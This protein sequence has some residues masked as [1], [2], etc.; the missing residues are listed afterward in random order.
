ME[1]II[2]IALLLWW[3]HGVA[4]ASGPWTRVI[5]IIIPPMAWCASIVKLTA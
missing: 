2:K 4:V 5:C 3:I 1:E